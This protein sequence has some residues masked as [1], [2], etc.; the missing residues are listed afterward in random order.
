LFFSLVFGTWLRG[1]ALP[2]P[3]GL[4][5]VP[6]KDGGEIWQ[7]RAENKVIAWSE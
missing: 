6:D 3:W 5:S 1:F 7:E 4:V 2:E